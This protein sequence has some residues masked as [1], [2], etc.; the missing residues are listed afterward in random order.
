MLSAKERKLLEALEPRAAQEGIEIVTIE[1]VGAKKSPTIRV[2]VDADGGVSF[3]VLAASQK[4]MGDI[5]EVIDPFPG[6]YVLEVS[7]PGIDRP[8]RTREHFE[9]FAGETVCVKTKSPVDGRSSLT[10]ELRGMVGDDVALDVDGTQVRVPLGVIKR[11]R[12][13]GT[14]DFSS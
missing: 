3:D 10:G 14:I 12:V 7:S 1:V 5:L 8:L 6:A 13:K 4:W 11:A 9:R 2:Y